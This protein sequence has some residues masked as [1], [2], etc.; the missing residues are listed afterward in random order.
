MYVCARVVMCVTQFNNN[1]NAHT[2]RLAQAVYTCSSCTSAD[3]RELVRVRSRPRRTSRPAII[4]L[5]MPNGRRKPFRVGAWSRKR[6]RYKSPSPSHS[7]DSEDTCVHKHRW[8]IL[9]RRVF[10]RWK[11]HARGMR[12]RRE[13]LRWLFYR[14]KFIHPPM[15]PII[16]RFVGPMSDT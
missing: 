4:G 8:I 6:R 2:Q 13:W 16:T 9:A 10:R 12:R 7:S 14:H 1:N 5:R 15:I 3:A 11:R